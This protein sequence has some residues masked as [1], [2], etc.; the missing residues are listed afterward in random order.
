MIFIRL[1]APADL[2][3][4]TRLVDLV[5]DFW[6]RCPTHKTLSVIEEYPIL[7]SDGEGE[8]VIRDQKITVCHTSARLLSFESPSNFPFIFDCRYCIYDGIFSA[9]LL[10]REC[11]Y[12]CIRIST[13]R[14][15]ARRIQDL[16]NASITSEIESAVG[17]WWRGGCAFLGR[18]SS[19]RFSY[20]SLW[21]DGC[22]ISS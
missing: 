9:S 16:G 1:V 8:G 11:W 21:V 2:L 18:G 20:H 7:I 12:E 14:V 6:R 13:K 22:S 5:F 10:A 17:K 3:S 19:F 15:A 4:M